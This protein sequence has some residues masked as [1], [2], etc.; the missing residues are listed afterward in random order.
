MPRH[1][2]RRF[3]QVRRCILADLLQ[4]VQY[5]RLDLFIT[6]GQQISQRGENL[7][8]SHTF[9]Q[10]GGSLGARRLVPIAVVEGLPSSRVHRTGL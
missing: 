10:P 7:L 6:R 8:V 2:A 4:G 5:L 3:H 9:A 1:R